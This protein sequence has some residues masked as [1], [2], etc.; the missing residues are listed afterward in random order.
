MLSTLPK[1]LNSS[2][3]PKPFLKWAGGKTQILEQIKN[4]LPQELCN[5]SIKKYV[6]PFIGGGAVFFT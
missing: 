5:G 6:E 3:C 4:F 1:N 2:R